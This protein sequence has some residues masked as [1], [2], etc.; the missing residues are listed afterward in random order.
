MFSLT[1]SRPLS[2]AEVVAAF[3]ALAPSGLRLVV[4]PPGADVPDDMGSLW[5]V[6]E[7]TEDPAW[8]LGLVVHVHECDLGPYPDL[9]LAEHLGERFGMDVLCGVDASLVEV[10]PHDPYYAL[11]LVGGSW[12]LAST[13]GTRLMGPYTVCDAGDL[14][15]EPGDEPVKLL[16]PVV[17]HA[18]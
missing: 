4:Q 7:P 15:N 11:A 9:R 13:A 1:V 17:V 6:L 16:R 18:L 2:V 5:A 12:Y 14:R 8:P 3:V 10:D